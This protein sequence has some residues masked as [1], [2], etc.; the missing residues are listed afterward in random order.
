[1]QTSVK[2]LIIFI[3]I[4]FVAV[5]LGQAGYEKF[6]LTLLWICVFGGLG[7]V[8]WFPFE[9]VKTMLEKERKQEF[10]QKLKEEQEKQ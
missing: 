5:S 9:F 3:V 8:I 4:G 1:M 6:S 7:C 2:T 10:E